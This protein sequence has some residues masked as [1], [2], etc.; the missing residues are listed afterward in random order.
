MIYKINYTGLIT[1]REQSNEHYLKS[2]Q[3]SLN[4]YKVWK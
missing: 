3:E 1:Y 4:M 2:E